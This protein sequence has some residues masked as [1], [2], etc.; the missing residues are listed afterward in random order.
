MLVESSLLI[1]TFL[2]L[3]ALIS[4]HRSILVL[5][6]F[7]FP[8]LHVF[9]EANGGIGVVELAVE[10]P[11]VR[12]CRLFGAELNQDWSNSIKTCCLI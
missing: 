8:A 10:Q 4:E 9:G 6:P 1:N 3:S 7:V 2:A 11:A 12:A 5:D